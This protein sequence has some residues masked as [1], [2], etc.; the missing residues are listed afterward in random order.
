MAKID[1]TADRIDKLRDELSRLRP[2]SPSVLASIQEPFDFEL[3]YSSNAIEGNTLTLRETEQV[4]AHGVTVA[5]KKLGDHLEAIDH[6]EALHWAYRVAASDEPITAMTIR[7]LHQLVLAKSKP[8]IAGQLAVSQR[9]IRGS[10]VVFP[11]AAEVRPLM[12]DLGDDLRD[13]PMTPRSAFD[14]HRRLVT[15]HP[16]DDG[17]GRTAR[18]LMNLMLVRGGYRPVAIGTAERLAY[19]ATLERSQ[20]TGDDRPFQLF[21]HERLEATMREYVTTVRQAAENAAALEGVDGP[22]AA[23]LAHWHGQKGVGR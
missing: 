22:T 17:N 16:F 7:Q 8:D 23:E 1:E 20:L 3:T 6:H 12:T 9:A 21:M 13:A 18:L 14:A 11:S 5:G 2:L 15:V 10:D 4:I 19:L